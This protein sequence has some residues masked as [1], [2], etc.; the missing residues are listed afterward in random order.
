M[1]NRPKID[2]TIRMIPEI[3][4]DDYNR[5]VDQVFY[6]YD[7]HIRLLLDYLGN[8]SECLKD[9]LTTT[10]FP[11]DETGSIERGAINVESL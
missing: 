5:Y 2:L 9:F 8:E 10:S 11:M 4:V 1:E 6:A 7:Y 3:S